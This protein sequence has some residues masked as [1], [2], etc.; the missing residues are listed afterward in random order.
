MPHADFTFLGDGMFVAPIGLFVV[1]AVLV[2]VGGLASRR[3]ARQR[4]AAFGAWFRQIGFEFHV[5]ADT[6]LT[7]RL[8]PFS[9]FQTGSN[10]YAANIASGAMRGRPSWCFDHHYETTSTDSEGRHQTHHHWSSN[11]V[12]DCGLALSDLSIRSESWFDKIVGALGFDDI[13]FES[14]EFSRLFHVKARDRRWAYDVI[15]TGVMDLLLRS[16]RFQIE[17]SGR[18]LLLRR[19][20]M[21]GPDVYAEAMQLGHALIDSLPKD[22]AQERRLA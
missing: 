3:R 15:H 18:H 9:C 10:R 22:I 8:G 20:G 13:D 19:G 7:G 12:I 4:Q 2:V 17:M 5:G 16:P 11:V 1:F 6:T 21:F 14:N